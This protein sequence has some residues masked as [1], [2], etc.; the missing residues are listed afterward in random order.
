MQ[1]QETTLEELRAGLGRELGL[2]PWLEVSQERVDRF[3]DVTDDHQ[4]IHVD[5][6]RAAQTPFGG[7]IAHGLLTLSLIV[8]LCLERVPK[9]RGTRLVLNYGFDRVRFVAPV[10]V[11]KRIRA[12][13]R[14]ADATLRK[15]GQV[16][17]KLEVTIEI[18]GEDKPALTAE[19]LS[20]HVTDG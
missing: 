13:A 5:P 12:A 1:Q 16:L 8:H 14:L 20:L 10:R 3:A 6:E 15:A 7:T 9:L 4:Y 17:V 11:G 2:S 18:E 19:W